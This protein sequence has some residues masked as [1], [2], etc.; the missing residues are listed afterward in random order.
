MYIPV[1]IICIMS[2]CVCVCVCVCVCDFNLSL[3]PDSRNF[4]RESGRISNQS[5]VP[6][7]LEYD[8]TTSSFEIET[9]ES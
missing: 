8:L 5:V 7:G 3:R 9:L 2:I 6:R 1:Y 4:N